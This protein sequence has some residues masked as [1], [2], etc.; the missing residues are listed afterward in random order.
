[1][2]SVTLSHVSVH[3]ERE[4][5]KLKPLKCINQF[6]GSW[7]FLRTANDSSDQR[8]SLLLE[9]AKFISFIT[10]FPSLNPITSYLNPVHI[11]TSCFFKIQFKI[12]GHLLYSGDKNLRTY[13]SGQ[14][15]LRQWSMSSV[16][17]QVHVL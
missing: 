5:E 9:A 6:Y 13:L 2:N 8:N 11:F 14:S 4:R 7:Y 17:D 10:K 16:Q 1:M 12:I 15:K 3:R